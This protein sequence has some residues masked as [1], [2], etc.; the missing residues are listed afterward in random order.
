MDLTE[1]VIVADEL[2]RLYQNGD[3][4]SA[5]SRSFPVSRS[6]L[7]RY[8]NC[9]P[10]NMDNG[11]TSSQVRRAAYRIVGLDESD[12]VHEKVAAFIA[13]IHGLSYQEIRGK[14]G[15][16]KV[17]VFRMLTQAKDALNCQRN[18]ESATPLQDIKELRTLLQAKSEALV[19][20][21]AWEIAEAAKR[22]RKP[23]LSNTE[24]AVHA[25]LFSCMTNGGIH[26][27]ARQIQVCKIHPF[28][29]LK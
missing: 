8:L 20:D 9:L 16:P 15:V 11:K 1:K 18:R 29:P 24:V 26:C 22:G 28:T 10:P 25:E 13:A 17:T 14:Y 3:S 6:T 19:E 2:V 23:L 7:Q 4:I 12:V 21:L 5:V 27:S